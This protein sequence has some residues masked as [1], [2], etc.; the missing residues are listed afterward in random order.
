M[1]L[2]RP[3]PTLAA[4]LIAAAATGCATPPPA[5]DPEALADFRQT[6]DP[7]EP[8]NRV[9]YAINNGID[10]VVMRPIAVGY[11]YAVPEVV[12]SHVHNVLVNL[13]DPVVLAND[14]MEG[15][16]HRA[17]DTLVR[18]VVNSTV[19]VA[20]I[21]DVATG[22]G[23]PDHDADFGMTLAL[24]GVPEGPFLYLPILGPSDPRD[25]IGFGAD[26]VTSPF[27]WIGKGSTVTNLEYV[28]YGMTAVDTR[29]A[30]L[31]DL[32]KVKEQALDPYA[33]F[34]SLYRQHRHAQI[35]AAGS[36]NRATTP[37]WYPDAPAQH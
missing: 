15:K 20:G 31:A 2:P 13:N 9:L 11:H 26:V 7:L 36:D 29:T 21:F 14:M 6:N 3:A 24:W 37:A 27:T 18:F 16:P 5:S 19:G 35:E 17:G 8:A 25:A 23:Y 33:T 28:Q 10:E 1:R 4:L 12:R 30:L 32:D 22:L 34:R